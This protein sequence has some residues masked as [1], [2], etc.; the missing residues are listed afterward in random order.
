MILYEKNKMSRSLIIASLVTILFDTISLIFIPVMYFFLIV[1]I[2]KVRNHLKENMKL[3][4]K[5]DERTSKNICMLLLIVGSNV[6][7]W[8]PIIVFCTMSVIGHS[9]HPSLISSTTVLVLP[10]NPTLNPF[11]FTF[12]S[13]EFKEF[14]KSQLQSIKG[15]VNTH[16]SRIR[17]DL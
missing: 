4:D 11:F 2:M 17:I 3:K 16:F 6:I 14:Y 1:E 12:L 7:S 5:K 8:V 13:S 10:I 15:Y 9:I